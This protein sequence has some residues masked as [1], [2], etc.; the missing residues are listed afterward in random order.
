MAKK[1]QKSGLICLQYATLYSTTQVL[2]FEIFQISLTC[3][4]AYLA[5][6]KQRHNCHGKGESRYVFEVAY[7]NLA[8]HISLNP[9]AR[10]FA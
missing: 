3:L 9:I 6:A 5:G 1:R 4:Q 10:S 2:L 7:R 8:V